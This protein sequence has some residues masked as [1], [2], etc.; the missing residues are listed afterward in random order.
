[1]ALWTAERG[2]DGGD[3]VDG[4]T[5]I[6]R[7]AGSVRG[8]YWDGRDGKGGTSTNPELLEPVGPELVDGRWGDGSRKV[9]AVIELEL[10]DRRRVPLTLAERRVV[11]GL[12]CD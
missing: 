7:R 6:V 11:N 2:D 5:L 12:A 9:L 3:R 8:A 4:S 1:M 10:F